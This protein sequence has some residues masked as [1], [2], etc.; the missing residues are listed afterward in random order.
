MSGR[1]PDTIFA[2]ST[3]RGRAGIAVVRVSGPLVS[4]V[5]AEL[6]K[7]GLPRPRQATRRRFLG[8]DGDTIDDGL[9]LWFPSPGSFTGEDLAELHLHGGKAILDAIFAALER[10]GLRP[11]EGGEFT[12]RAV[13]NGKLD[14]TGAE[15]VA[16]LIAAETAA[17]LRQAIAQYGGALAEQCEAWRAQLVTI[18]A[19]AEAGIDFSDEELPAD[20][21]LS[22]HTKISDIIEQIQYVNKDAQIGELVRDGLYLTVIGPPNAGKSSLVNMLARRD[23]AI[24]SE[25]AGTT[26]DV[27]EVHLDL[28]GYQVIVSDT[29]GL[30]ETADTVETEG[31]RRALASASKAN[32]VLL[33]LDGSSPE[34]FGGVSRET[35]DSADLIV[36]NKQD[37]PWSLERK[38]M[39]ISLATGQGLD[40]LVDALTGLVEARLQ[41][42]A[43]APL[44]TRARHRHA[45]AGAVEA[46]RR[47]LEATSVE[48]CA[49]DL[50]LALRAIGRVTGRVDI[51]ELLDVVFRD[52]C[53]GK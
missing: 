35:V 47:A 42:P 29:A 12:R 7:K 19:W 34:A 22:V 8:M 44:V 1:A 52:F 26:R 46:L 28:G 30:R 15:A 17:Q 41:S 53:I 45:L 33:L 43:E 49:E 11:A 27:I 51:E 23:I 40:G 38:G 18:S 50:R 21:T 10:L 25:V 13:E 32:I 9:V 2:L 4:T 3:G 36:W 39:S 24:V 37:L 31:V 6:T 20:L 48:L 14:L 5:L 16:D